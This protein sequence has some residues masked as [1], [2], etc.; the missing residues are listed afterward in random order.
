[1]RPSR[2]RRVRSPSASAPATRNRRLRK[3]SS[4]WPH[5]S[6]WRARRALFPSRSHRKSTLAS[7][8]LSAGKSFA[9]RP[10]YWRSCR[11]FFLG[12]RRPPTSTLF[13]Y[14]TLFRT[15]RRARRPHARPSHDHARSRST[16]KPPGGDRKSTRLNSSHS[17]ISYAVFCL[18]KKKK[19]HTIFYFV[20]KKK[21]KKTKRK[22]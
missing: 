8:Y 14:T 16:R 2:I 17:S 18:K 22:S 1:M 15:R 9:K 10:G 21:R 11:F 20:K 3:A 19:N 6:E 13:P 12:I 5:G 4:P 7:V